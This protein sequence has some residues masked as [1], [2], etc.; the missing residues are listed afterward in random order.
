M[1]ERSDSVTRWLLRGIC[2]SAILLVIAQNALADWSVSFESDSVIA[3]AVNV[4]I[5]VS[6]S[7]D[8][9]LQ[10]L[11]VPTIVRSRDPGAFWAGDLPY[12][13][14]GVATSH[15]YSLGVIWSWDAPW[16]FNSEQVRPSSTVHD[17]LR[18]SCGPDYD[19]LYNGVSPDQ[20]AISADGTNGTPAKPEGQQFLTLM[21]DV[22]DVGGE[23]EFDTA[24]FSDNLYALF[25]IDGD[26]PPTDHGP[27]GEDEA[28]FTKGVITIVKDSDGDGILDH[29]DNCPDDPNPAQIDGDGDDVGDAC[30]NCPEEFNQEQVDGDGDGIGDACD[31]CPEDPNPDHQLPGECVSGILETEDQA[32]QDFSLHQN[33]PNP[34]NANTVIEF[35]LPRASYVTLGIYNILGERIINLVD[36]YR[37]AGVQQ[38]HWDGRDRHDREVSSGIYFY[39]LTAGDVPQHKKMVL[40]K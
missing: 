31:G 18:E 21:F 39:R 28:T 30:D 8:K 6:A 17:T 9:T 19:S 35:T 26:F 22:T 14:L 10:A 15:P 40:L 4:T 1:V 33:Y 27:D 16:A 29:D 11:T 5:G 23:F 24:C 34:F 32:P 7:W 38:V 36:E 3:G 37:S 25:M 2:L 20:F 12:D 13:T